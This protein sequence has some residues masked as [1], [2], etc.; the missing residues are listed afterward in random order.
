MSPVGSYGTG[1]GPTCVFVE[2][3]LGS[4]VYT[5]NFLD[6]T[7]S[8]LNID[9]SYG[10]RSRRCRTLRSSPPASPPVSPQLI[11]GKHPPI[12]STN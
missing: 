4:Y 8:G 2:P 10:R 1:T 6:N 7:I 11:H 3:A 9:M 5:T 12:T